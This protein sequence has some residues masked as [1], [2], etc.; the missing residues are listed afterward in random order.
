MMQPFDLAWSV[1]IV[2]Q[3]LWSFEGNIQI[4]VGP[5][6]CASKPDSEMM[7][8]IY[9][10]FLAKYFVLPKKLGIICIT[11]FKNPTRGNHMS[12]H[13]TN[14]RNRHQVSRSQ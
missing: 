1:E 13:V 5:F 4:P 3:D 10:S 7:E 9:A 6:R 2:F 11:S 8:Q 14:I 12:Q